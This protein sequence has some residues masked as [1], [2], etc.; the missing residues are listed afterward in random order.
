MS[1]DGLG[2]TPDLLRAVADQG[3]TVP[4]PVQAETIPLVL[5]GRDVLAGAQTGT[6]KTAAFVLPIL[7]KL[8]ASRPY[9]DPRRSVR[10]N[11]PRPSHRTPVRVL[12]L[13]PTR[14]LAV[15]VEE[16]VR[17]YGA[18]RPIRSSAIYGGVGFDPQARA[19]RSG[20]ELVVATPG[21]LLD[22]VNQRTIDLSAVE[23]LVLDEADRMLD[24]GFIRDIRK[25]LALLPE[26]RQNLLFSATFSDEIRRLADSFLDR[27]ATIQVT[28]RNT[29][30]DLVTQVAHRVDRERK[31]DLLVH[32][33]KSGRIDKALVF[34]RTKHGAERLAGQLV[35]EGIAATAIHGNRSQSQRQ[36]ALDSFKTGRF[37]IL[38]ATE[39]AAR[40]LDIDALPHVV[41]YEMPMVPEDYL[42]R[43][44][45]TA[46]AG[47]TG[48]AISLVC[49]DEQKLLWDIERVLGH[50][51]PVE[52][53]VGFEPDPRIRAEPILRRGGGQGGAQ[54]GHRGG[55]RPIGRGHPRSFPTRGP[56][57]AHAGAGHGHPSAGHGHPSRSPSQGHP[58]PSG[59]MTVMPGERIARHVSRAAG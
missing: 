14:E 1:F 16:S 26:R 29:A 43:I 42:H 46:R 8:N 33:I 40:G 54:G 5:A 38:V 7:Q 52:V 35:R 57:P 55:P 51:I 59:P 39:V 15:Q 36:R 32:L 6:G 24:M 58:R 27:P 4:T 37:T 3:Y 12:V 10:P 21:R 19:L 18:R 31:R 25:I 56:R 47:L 11:G 53:I 9:E 30:T 49:V 2:L 45:R 13:T 28:P 20:R 48:D 50:P 23:I 44:G 17:T 41:N 34:T 22:H